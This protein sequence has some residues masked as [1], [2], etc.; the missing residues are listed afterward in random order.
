MTYVI[1]DFPQSLTEGDKKMCDHATIACCQILSSSS[2][3]IHH[4]PTRRKTTY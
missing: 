2:A 4:M 1:R 3:T